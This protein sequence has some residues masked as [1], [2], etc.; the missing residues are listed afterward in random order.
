[1]LKNKS[2][3]RRLLSLDCK[4]IA[5]AME[6]DGRDDGMSLQKKIYIHLSDRIII[7]IQQLFS[8]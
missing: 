2:R 5:N 8:C 6:W 4:F 3:I 1:M 7:Y